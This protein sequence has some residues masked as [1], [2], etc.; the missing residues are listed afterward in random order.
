VDVLL[1]EDRRGLP[2]DEASPSKPAETFS[3]RITWGGRCS[4]LNP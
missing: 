3:P 2:H 4:Q 1:V